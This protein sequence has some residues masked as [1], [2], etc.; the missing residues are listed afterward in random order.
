LKIERQSKGPGADRR[1]GRKAKAD[2]P[3]GPAIDLDGVRGGLDRGDPAIEGRIDVDRERSGRD[4][5]ERVRQRQGDIDAVARGG[6]FVAERDFQLG[7]IART[8]NDRPDSERV[9]AE[10]FGQIGIE[11]QAADRIVEDAESFVADDR[12]FGRLATEPRIDRLDSGGKRGEKRRR[13]LV[14]RW[15][16]DR[17]AKDG[18]GRASVKGHRSFDAFDSDLI[19][20]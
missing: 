6:Q 20:D 12:C 15:V 16:E 7:A 3:L 19:L 5:V 4:A 17:R 10:E 1:A 9:A 13:L 8:E 14:F 18:L 2:A 11:R